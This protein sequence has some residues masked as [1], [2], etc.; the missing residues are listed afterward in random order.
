MILE[1]YLNLLYL[2]HFN[3]FQVSECANPDVRGVLGSLP[4]LFMATGV[5]MSYIIG[6]YLPWNYLAFVSAVFPAALFF[7]LLPLPES[8]CW[9]QSRG[10]NRAA[11]KSSM[12]LKH[13]RRTSLE[14]K[15]LSS[16]KKATTVS[17][18]ETE[19][20][21]ILS[22]STEHK[23]LSAHSP[24]ALL[25]RPVLIP[26]AL[27]VC[28]LIF[29]QFSGI[30]TVLFY[31]VSIFEASGTYVNNYLATIL[32]GVVQ[33]IAT[34]IS[35]FI[36]DRYGRK[37]LLVISGLVMAFSM[38]ALGCYFYVHN[39]KFKIAER[40]N[41]LP[42]FSLTVFIG[43]FSLGFAGVPFLLMAELLPFTQR[44]VLSSVASAF[45]LDSMFLVIK[46]YSDIKY[47]IG[48]EGVFCGYAI[49]CVAGSLFVLYFIPETKGTKESH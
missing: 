36:I 42:V 21:Q 2:I 9:L 7:F 47:L 40:L 32:V 45:N 38:A 22:K 28:T 5:L 6:T 34:I 17:E 48:D 24:E 35:L 20:K 31:T 18:A 23:P 14:L 41:L 25:R 13:E 4:A 3:H 26:F 49:I 46:S 19:V 30:D 16:F 27:V 1:P 39:K 33:V 11:Q 29:Q 15:M 43:A 8:P 10:L 12:W 44:S 37:P